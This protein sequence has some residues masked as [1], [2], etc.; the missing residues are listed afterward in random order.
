MSTTTFDPGAPES[1]AQGH[2][3]VSED[4]SQ[5]EEERLRR[6]RL[7]LGSSAGSGLSAQDTKLDTALHLLYD[8]DRPKSGQ[9]RSAGLGASAPKLATWLGD[10]RSYFPQTVVQVM[11]RDAINRLGLR[12]LLLE[13]ETLATLQPDV[14]LVSTLI[15]LKKLIPEQTKQTG[16]QVVAD[17]VEQ[18]RKRIATKTASAVRGA[19]KR[20]VR[21]RR[22][23]LPDINWNATIRANLKNYLPEQRTVIPEQLIGYG[24]SLPSF[25]K[26]VVV[27]IDQ[28]GSMAESV[29]YA[30]IFGA[31]LASLPAVRTSVVAFDTSVLDLTPLL[32]DP[33]ELL[34]GTQ[35]G[36]GTDINGAVAYCQS[37]ITRPRDTV[38]VLI[39]D[40]Y[41]GGVADQ[42]LARM[43]ALRDSG[44]A[45]VALLSLADT[46]APAYD[47]ELAAQLVELG[48]PAFACTPDAFPELLAAA[49]RGDSLQSWVE[50][51]EAS[52]S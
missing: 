28:S 22:P 4:C 35:L 43:N 26:H 19:L 49:I 27:A 6:W 42:L 12:Q 34:F 30:G 41:E 20:G 39:S 46:G 29:V 24:R 40:L 15:S 2:G 14:N 48:V 38:F 10:I 23:R 36:G 1:G 18:V 52:R 32:D 3:L 17:V 11:Q 21:S 47:H 9:G 44:V 33:V 8:S 45:C 51:E 25:S 7:L 37:L 16:R 31:V 13:P 5:D 50:K